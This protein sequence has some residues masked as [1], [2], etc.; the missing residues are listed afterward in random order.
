MVGANEVQIVDFTLS[1][2]IDL[3]ANEGLD[4][5]NVYLPNGTFSRFAIW[6]TTL[7][8][9]NNNDTIMHI[10]GPPNGSDLSQSGVYFI[11]YST[12]GGNIV[13]YDANDTNHFIYD[14]TNHKLKIKCSRPNTYL[15]A[16]DY[17]LVIW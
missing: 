8:S 14:A 9:V 13:L 6:N 17:R 11:Y 12:V 4:I 1:E 2:D 15:R 10:Y 3:S 5:N 16:G 7:L